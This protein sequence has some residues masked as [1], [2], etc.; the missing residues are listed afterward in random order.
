MKEHPV[1]ELG[2]CMNSR[3]WIAFMHITPQTCPYNEC[4]Y[5]PCDSS[6]GYWEKRKASNSIKNKYKL[7]REDV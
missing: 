6:C 3:R 7:F 1:E 4:D 2:F 5:P